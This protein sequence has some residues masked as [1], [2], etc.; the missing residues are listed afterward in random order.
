MKHLTRFL[1][2]FVL[3]FILC[4]SEPQDMDNKLSRFIAEHVKEIQPLHIEGGRAQ[5]RASTTGNKE[6]YERME[7]IELQVRRIL[8]DREAFAQLKRW[9][10]SDGVRAPRLRRQLDR[11]YY[12][13]L[14]NQIDPALMKRI[15]A[16][17]TDITERFNTFQIHLDGKEV[18]LNDLNDVLRASTDSVQ[19]E[20]AWRASKQVGP[21]I[22]GDLAQLA[23]LRNEGARALG[24]ANFHTMCL[25]T[26][27]QDPAELDR[28]FAELEALTREP[29]AALKAELDRALTARY[30]I[31]PADLRPWH[32]H[33]PFFQNAPLVMG[34]DLD[35]YYKDHDIR[36]LAEKFYAGIGLPV[37][38]VLARSD[39]YERPK[40]DP[41]AF[42][43]DID[44][45]G[46]VRVLC[47]LRNNAK[48]METLLHELGHAVYSKGHDR[49][50][51]YILRVPAHSFATEGVAMFFGRLGSNAA[52]MQAMLGLPD[53]ARAAIEKSQHTNDRLQQLIFA[54]W[55]LVMFHFEK[56]LYANPDQNLDTLWWQLVARHQLLTPPADPPA[57]VWAAKPHFT[58][59][60]CYYHN[61]MLG[62]LFASQVH[63]HLVHKVLGRESDAG[64]SYAG[65]KEV[66]EFLR[67]K[68]FGPG[69]VHPWNEM[70]ARA[71]G[72]PLTAKYFVA[73]FVK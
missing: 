18:T 53:E 59:A 34:E 36:A 16:L 49:G 69:A 4:A 10:E 64:V 58:I 30:K 5:W 43:T 24:F 33:D 22:A 15:V 56:Q 21:T 37:T 48:W 72:E 1:P 41:H 32:Y 61:Y 54:R 38:D 11:L 46:D 6:D 55:A 62:E 12:A 25:L 7:E 65:R 27:E 68:V 51:P 35:E 23:R 57:G 42:S 39:L 47:N 14:E 3:P 17:S 71:T 67:E 29:F 19:R 63:N 60:P 52:W 13:Y 70:I 2:A 9:R 45:E 44:R 31:A 28:I 73:Q 66:G 50:E 20:A 8:S 40:K 26:G